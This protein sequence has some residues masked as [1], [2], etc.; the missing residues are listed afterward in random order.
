MAFALLPLPLGRNSNGGNLGNFENFDCEHV[1]PYIPNRP[2]NFN[3]K[4]WLPKAPVEPLGPLAEARGL[5]FNHC[6][7]WRS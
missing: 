2:N 1:E 4:Y 3:I 5:D 7:T 6:E